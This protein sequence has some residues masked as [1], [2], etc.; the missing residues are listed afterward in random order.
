MTSTQVVKIHNARIAKYYVMR[1]NESPAFA[2]ERTI[3]QQRGFTLIELLVV[4]AIIAIP[5]ALLLPT[6]Q[7][8][9]E[10]AR[11]NR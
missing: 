3:N 5:V 7:Q 10:A 1:W 9:R 4:I 11:R 2:S 8:A 6:A